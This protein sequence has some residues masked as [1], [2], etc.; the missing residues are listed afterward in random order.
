MPFV[1][2]GKDYPSSRRLFAELGFE[3][4]WESGGYAGFQNGEAGFILQDL[5]HEAFA[6]NLMIQM[7]VPNLERWWQAISS[8][9]LDRTY[10]GFRIKAPLDFPWGR[11]IHFIDLAGVCWHV[12]ER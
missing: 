7:V 1:P 4:V 8:K 11:E 2:A 10:P 5:D 6:S 12:R 9:A 3:E